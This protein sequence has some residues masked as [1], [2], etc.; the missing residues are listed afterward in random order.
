MDRPPSRGWRRLARAAAV[1]LLAAALLFPTAAFAEGGWDPDV[2]P[3]RD[4]VWNKSLNWSGIAYQS[5]INT[6]TTGYVSDIKAQWLVPT[7]NC[8]ST[9]DATSSMWI[10]IDGFTTSTTVEQIGTQHTCNNGVASYSAFYEMYPSPPVTFSLAVKPGDQVSA[11]IKYAAGGQFTLSLTNLTT[12]QSYATTQTS[13]TAL[14]T[15][16]EFILE[17]Q[18][19]NGVVTPLANVGTVKFTNTSM[20]LSGNA[21]Q[22]VIDMTNASGVTLADSSGFQTT[23][24]KA[25]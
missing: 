19:V 5:S 4:G 24:K 8:A 12:G 23:W 22:T 15:S 7:L 14:R 2:T 1:P 3:L 18:T 6:P 9:P 25:S 13:L 16:A 17:A 21:N 20:V 10:G 11:E